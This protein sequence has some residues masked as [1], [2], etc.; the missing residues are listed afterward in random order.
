MEDMEYVPTRVELDLEPRANPNI[1]GRRETHI[2]VTPHPFRVQAGHPLI[3]ESRYRFA[4]HF[5]GTA[6]LQ[7]G[8]V[9]LVV[10]G[11]VVSEPDWLLALREQDHVVCE[12]P[13][14]SG[15][16]AREDGARVE[17][18]KFAVSLVGEDGRVHLADPEGVLDPD[19]KKDLRR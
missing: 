9:E 13:F 2:L 19:P 1:P 18:Y 8:L 11:K 17:T 15:Q 4:V 7:D 5:V 3:F 14:C 10:N 16:L 12:L 6:P